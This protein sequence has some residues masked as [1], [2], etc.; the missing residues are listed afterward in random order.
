MII[1][2]QESQLSLGELTVLVTAD[3]LVI[4]DCRCFRDIGPKVEYWGHDLDFSAVSGSQNVIGH[5]TIRFPIGYS[6]K[7]GRKSTPLVLTACQSVT[8]PVYRID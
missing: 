4:S 5:V 6:T 2:K 7:F 8:L 3:Y 1:I